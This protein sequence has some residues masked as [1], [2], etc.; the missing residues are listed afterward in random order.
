MYLICS[1]LHLSL[2]FWWLGYNLCKSLLSRTPAFLNTEMFTTFL[3]FPSASFAG[4]Y[5]SFYRWFWLQLGFSKFLWIPKG[6]SFCLQES[7]SD[8]MKTLSVI[9]N[10]IVCIAT[11]AQR[12]SLCFSSKGLLSPAAHELLPPT[13]TLLQAPLPAP[14]WR[15]FLSLSFPCS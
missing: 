5:C 14:S 1:F 15:V 7:W 11:P 3:S 8:L 2:F 6:A 4:V 10:H 13:F 9:G 12:A